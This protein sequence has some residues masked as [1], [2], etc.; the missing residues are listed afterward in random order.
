VKKHTTQQFIQNAQ[1]IHGNKYDYS[2]VNY[3]GAMKK[4]T[5]ICKEHGKFNQI[6]NDHI[7]ARSGCPKCGII[8]KIV[9]TTLTT[10]QFIEKSRR[11]HG[12]LYDYS[13]TK[14]TGVHNKVTII[15]KEHGSFL[16]TPDN[17]SNAGFGCPRCGTIASHTA[18]TLTTEQFIKKAKLIH[19]DLYNYSLV[20]CVG[21]MKKVTIIC[22][23]HGSFLQIPNDHT[24]RKSG[25]PACAGNQT[26]TAKQFIESARLIHGDLYDYSQTKYTN[27][28]NKITIIC[29]EHG[30]FLQIPNAHISSKSGCPKC[31]GYVSK[32]ETNW[33]DSLG[34]PD[35]PHFRQVTF[36]IKDRRHK[37]DGFDP[38]TNT[39]YEFWGDFWHGNPV[40][41]NP[42]DVNPINYKTFGELY[43]KTQQKRQS[44]LNAGY[45]LVEIWES[46]YDSR[47]YQLP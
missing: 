45:N 47:I 15:C 46:D 12:D 35:T 7:N 9:V 31:V 10:E 26:S 13:Q 43:E 22:K 24:S 40:K 5:I 30:P 25:C 11:I 20:N 2:L 41:Y 44:I 39:V 19:G 16:Q 36:K 34:V 6:P 8:A 33:L 27:A 17:H 18:A 14:Y 42:I 21:V 38:E 4:V 28:H 3:V 37:V 1:N 32:K 23:E 29:K